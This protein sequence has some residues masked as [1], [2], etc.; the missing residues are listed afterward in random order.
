VPF[1]FTLQ[2]VLQERKRLED[3]T[4]LPF[5][6]HQDVGQ[7]INLSTT[8]FLVI[9]YESLHRL[10]KDWGLGDRELLVLCDEWN[11]IMR[12]MESNAGKPGEDMLMF[13]VSSTQ[14]EM[15]SP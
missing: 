4:G 1:T 7:D 2:H 15:L 3:E 5:V 6:S 10:R 8:P 14:N 11:S 13:L 12:Q 9:Q